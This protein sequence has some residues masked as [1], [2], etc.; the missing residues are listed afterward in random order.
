MVI[1]YDIKYYFVTEL[2][3]EKERK[4]KPS[5]RLLVKFLVIGSGWKQLGD[6]YLPSGIKG[7]PE[8]G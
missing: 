1:A 3:K 4:R 5:S 8:E 7:I 6:T 2:L